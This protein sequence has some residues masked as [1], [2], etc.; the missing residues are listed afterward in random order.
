MVKFLHAQ[1]VFCP[2]PARRVALIF[3][4]F[5]LTG[6]ILSLSAA[7]F[8]ASL[9]RSTT[10]V[11]DNVTLNLVCVDGT[12]QGVPGPSPILGI[13]IAF[14][15]QSSQAVIINNKVS[16]TDSFSYQL[17]PTRAGNYVIPAIQ[18]EVDGKTVMTQPLALRVAAADPQAMARIA[19]LK[20]VAGKT[21]IFAGELVPV[22]IQLFATGGRILQPAEVQGDGFLFG[23]IAMDSEQESVSTNGMEYRMVRFRTYVSA[24]RTGPLQLGP[25]TLKLLIPKPNGRRNFFGDLEMR[26]YTVSADAVRMNVMPLPAQNVPPTFHGAI[27]RYAVAVTAGPTNLGVGD[28]ITVNIRVSGKGSLPSLSLPEQPAWRE[29]R[30]YPASGK[31]ETADQFETEGVKTFEQVV[32]P[33]NADI[34]VLPPFAF[35][36]FDPEQKRYL[37]L[38][39]R[40]IPLTVHP[41]AATPQPTILA[42]NT[43]SSAALPR[44]IVHIKTQLG[45]VGPPPLPLVGQRW[46]LVLQLFPPLLWLIALLWRRQKER[47]AK[48]PKLRRQRELARTIR[49]GLSELRRLAAANEGEEFFATLFRLLQEQVGE[50]LDLPSSAITEAVVDE[51][52][53]SRGV[54]EPTLALL[55]ELFQIC[56]QTRYAMQQSSDALALFIPKTERVLHE[57]QKIKA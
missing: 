36:Y 7:T 39:S 22:E 35:T 43:N 17:I 49:G 51:Q 44:E 34:K 45:L 53:R 57:L 40:P 24:A 52:L 30:I 14:A 18:A 28:P 26:P 25:A 9:D 13:D 12:I 21:E 54:P 15:G 3:L 10:S 2:K 27:G 4:V 41:A 56:N 23:K 19:F 11:G 16:K 48:N 55:H 29:F 31:I 46:F 42:Q 20:L 50:R 32:T 1:Q 33:Q 47:L 38:L 5:H 8:T 6:A 37:T